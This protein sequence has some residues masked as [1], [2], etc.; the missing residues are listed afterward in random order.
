MNDEIVFISDFFQIYIYIYC[1]FAFQITFI[2]VLLGTPLALNLRN[3]TWHGFPCPDEIKP[4]LG[5][6]LFIVIA[7]I[8]EILATQNCTVDSLPHRPQLSNMVYYSNLLEGC[9]PDLLR[10]KMEVE[11]VLLKSSHISHTHL[12]YWDAILE[13][14]FQSRYLFSFFFFCMEIY[15]Y[16]ML[17]HC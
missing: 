8:G 10:H 15:Y 9:F 13:H 2:Q 11:N 5:A 7:S 4:E 6:I 14:Y 12:V 17:T 1:L 16:V 3:V